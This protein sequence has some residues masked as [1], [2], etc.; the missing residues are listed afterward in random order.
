[1][2]KQARNAKGR[3][4]EPVWRKM[5]EDI[6]TAL[7]ERVFTGDMY[8]AWSPLAADRYPPSRFLNRTM[9]V[10]EKGIA[11]LVCKAWNRAFKAWVPEG[12]KGAAARAWGYEIREGLAFSQYPAY[13]W[14]ERL[15]ALY[16]QLHPVFLWLPVQ[17]STEMRL[18]VHQ[19]K[20]ATLTLTRRRVD[21]DNPDTDNQ[22]E[23]E[24]KVEIEAHRAP[25]RELA[26]KANWCRTSSVLEILIPH[27]CWT[28]DGVGGP[29]VDRFVREKSAFLDAWV[30]E[31]Y[32]LITRNWEA[33]TPLWREYWWR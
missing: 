3:F 6:Q 18:F 11:A 20:L 29:V 8:L 13:D 26:C 17:T 2:P 33:N 7:A 27:E 16:P 24:L 19:K 4:V 9:R 22:D 12:M 15:Q 21:W 10:G 30:V 28:E 32:A 5:D 25:R 31:Q 23:H 1:M 14:T